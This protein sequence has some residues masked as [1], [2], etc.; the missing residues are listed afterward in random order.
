VPLVLL[1]G[2]AEAQY[3]TPSAIGMTICMPA[4]RAWATA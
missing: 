4:A 1:V 3:G 2:S